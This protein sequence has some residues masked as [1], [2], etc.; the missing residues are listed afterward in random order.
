M[1]TTDNIPVAQ[2]PTPNW[3]AE[4]LQRRYGQESKGYVRRTPVGFDFSREPF[5]PSSYYKQLGTFRDIS[6]AATNVVQVEVANRLEAEQRRRQ[7]EDQK[8]LRDALGGIQPG[9]TY[10]GGGGVSRK[11]GLKGV[12]P[13]V[14]KAADYWGS[15]YSIRTIGGYRKHGSVPNSDHPKG[16]ALDFMINSGN[17]GS[18]LANDLIRNAKQWNVSY[19]IWNRAIWTPGS[20]WRKYYGPSPHTDHVH[21]SFNS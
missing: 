3:F 15:K 14:A 8:R 7:A 20:G 4:L 2:T 17:Q 21:A 1:A 18:A 6:R 10:D 9:Y 12:T 5:D 19:V 13:N 16:R 11:Y